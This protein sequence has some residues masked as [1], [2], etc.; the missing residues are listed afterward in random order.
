[1]I[2]GTLIRNQEKV[3]QSSTERLFLLF[4]FVKSRLG[5]TLLVRGFS[6]LENPRPM[7]WIQICFAR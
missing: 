3:L 2:K 5:T 7:S 1:M 4:D 6:D